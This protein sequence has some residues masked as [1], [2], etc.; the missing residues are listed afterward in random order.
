M[1]GMLI[2]QNSIKQKLRITVIEH[3]KALSQFFQAAGVLIRYDL[4]SL[5][6]NNKCMNKVKHLSV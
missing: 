1:D 3:S 6:S 4:L 2:F 5:P